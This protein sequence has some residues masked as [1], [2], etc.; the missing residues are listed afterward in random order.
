MPVLDC[1]KSS[2]QYFIFHVDLKLFTVRNFCAAVSDSLKIQSPKINELHCFSFLISH[3]S[4]FFNPQKFNPHFV[5][6]EKKLST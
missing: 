1:K 5:V 2:S 6:L 4:I 3:L